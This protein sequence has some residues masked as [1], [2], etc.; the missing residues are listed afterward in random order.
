MPTLVLSSGG[1]K[2]GRTNEERH[3]DAHALFCYVE[4][5]DCDAPIAQV[6]RPQKTERTGRLLLQELILKLVQ[7]LYQYT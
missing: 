7:S 2:T 4:K 6:L 3:H 5:R 1:A